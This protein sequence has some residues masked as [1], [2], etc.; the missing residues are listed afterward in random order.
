M[1]PDPDRDPGPN[2]VSNPDNS[3]KLLIIYSC[4]CVKGWR[5]IALMVC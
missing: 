1:C 3:E 4:V 2:P 5:T